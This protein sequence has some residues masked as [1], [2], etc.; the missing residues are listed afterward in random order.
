MIAHFGAPE[1][2]ALFTLFSVL[3]IVSI[4]YLIHPALPAQR[5][6]KLSPRI[7]DLNDRLIDAG[8]LVGSEADIEEMRFSL[9]KLGIKGDLL[10][11]SDTD[12]WAFY[13]PLLD[14]YARSGRIREARKLMS[15]TKGKGRRGSGLFP[16]LFLAFALAAILI[17][18][19]LV[20]E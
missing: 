16:V 13:L 11:K 14:A 12:A 20:P 1:Y 8:Y 2:A 10:D 3:L 17:C 15:T 19:W 18:L 9:S 7:R 4:W 5:F 6:K